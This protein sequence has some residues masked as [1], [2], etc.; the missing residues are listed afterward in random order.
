MDRNDVIKNYLDKKLI[1]N[2]KI[3]KHES[4]N[5]HYT[6][7]SK[8]YRTDVFIKIFPATQKKKFITEKAILFG[9]KQRYIDSFESLGTYFLVLQ[10]YYLQDI[11]QKQ[12][13]SPRK[14]INIA[15]IIKRFHFQNV[16]RFIDFKK[17]E[18]SDISQKIEKRI[19]EIDNSPYLDEVVRIW[20]ELKKLE[21][22]ANQEYN[23]GKYRVM[24]HGDFSIRNIKLLDNNPY[25]IDF[26]RVK[27]DFYFLD[28]IKFFYID[29]NNDDNR[30]N[31]FLSKYYKETGFEHISDILKYFLIFYTSIG[32][33]K[34][35]LFIKDTNFLGSAFRML[36]DVNSFIE[37]QGVQ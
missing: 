8:Y 11:D 27:L 20:K 21:Y 26:E 22:D 18:S 25:L 2:F 31:L 28:F 29:L 19:L 17:S 36:N 13:D 35:N 24:T 33:I 32:I 16:E 23:N 12:L 6:G 34:Y 30:V 7:F 5:S 4:L 37:K 15:N 3:L 14:I 9:N 1:G 10:D